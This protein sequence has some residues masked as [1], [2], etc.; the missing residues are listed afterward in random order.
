MRQLETQAS[1]FTPSLAGIVRRAAAT[2]RGHW[3]TI[4]AAAIISLTPGALLQGLA[5]WMATRESTGVAA[6]V[7]V[8]VAGAGAGM[9]GYF[10]LNGVIAQIAVARRRG[11]ERPGLAGI[12]RELPWRN[13]IVVDL[14]VSA[15][16]AIGLELLILPGLVFGTRFSLATVL[17]ETRSLEP[18]AALARSR[19]LTRGCFLRVLVLLVVPLAGVSALAYVLD[20]AI[21]GVFPWG[22]YV[23]RGIA[24]LIAAAV[25]KP[26]TSVLTVELA[27]ELDEHRP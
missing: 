12:A 8:I 7:V 9:L 15:G 5:A 22:E 23:E 27:I 4:A 3:G 6:L 14:I 17:V 2:H 13:L 21:A 20:G 24:A 25:L 11:Q 16:T 26:F 10:F 18:R 1:D 19:E